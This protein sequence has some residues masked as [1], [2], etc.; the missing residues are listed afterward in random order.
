[1]KERG[2]LGMENLNI[3]LTDLKAI[4]LAL[5]KF[6]PHCTEEKEQADE[7]LRKVKLM[8]V[9]M[10]NNHDDHIATTVEDKPSARIIGIMPGVTVPFVNIYRTAWTQQEA[11]Q[12]GNDLRRMGCT[13]IL[14]CFDDIDKLPKQ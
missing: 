9:D 11:W 13:E 2:A 1:M 14:E 8:I 12:I 10:D 4:E 7:A 3:T 5:E 6:V